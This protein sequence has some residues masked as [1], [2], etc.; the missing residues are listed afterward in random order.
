MSAQPQRRFDH[1]PLEGIREEEMERARLLLENHRSI[2]ASLSS[3]Q[4]R[5]VANMDV[6]EDIGRVNPAQ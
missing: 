3:S 5:A 6:P 1:S 4:R 2:L